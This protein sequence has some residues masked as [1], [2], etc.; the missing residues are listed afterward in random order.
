MKTRRIVFTVVAAM[1]M[2]AV[3]I[4]IFIFSN[5][6][7][8]VSSEASNS[9]GSFILELLHIEVPEGETPDSVPIVGGLTVRNLAHVFLF[10]LLGLTSYLFCYFG[11]GLMKPTRY[12]ALIAAGGALGISLLYACLDELHQRFIGGRSPRIRDVGIDAIGFCLMIA[13]GLAVTLLVEYFLQRA[14]DKKSL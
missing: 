2:L 1:L 10:S 4:T 13:V 5:Q 11:M 12:R 3:M 7:G 8:E 9:T 14:K 6:K